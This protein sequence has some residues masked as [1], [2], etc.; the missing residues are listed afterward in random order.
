MKITRS[1]LKQIIREE[2]GRNWNLED[3]VS[4]FI[5]AGPSEKA[6]E[7][8]EKLVAHAEA[9]GEVDW[10]SAMNS[11]E[12]E[13]TT[14]EYAKKRLEMLKSGSG[15]GRTHQFES[16]KITKSQLIRIIKEE[17]SPGSDPLGEVKATL[18][19][20]VKRAIEDDE[21]A[22]AQLDELAEYVEEISYGYL[23]IRSLY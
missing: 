21:D 1:Q 16:A 2:L 5:T 13:H 4:Y 19:D 23:K 12:P 20:L 17:L 11:H 9:G 8:L 7:Y 15:I 6:V 10:R 22:I 18:Q 3:N 14:L